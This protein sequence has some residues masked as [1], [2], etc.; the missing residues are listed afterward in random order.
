MILGAY[1]WIYVGGVSCLVLGAEFICE[2]GVSGVYLF[3]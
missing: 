2:E 3:R 1:V